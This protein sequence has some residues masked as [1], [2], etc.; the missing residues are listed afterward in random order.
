MMPI[1][2]FLLTSW[3][4]THILVKGKI[5][6]NQRNWLIIKSQFLEGVLTCHQCCGFWV[7][8]I[9]YPFF[10]DLPDCF[11]LYVDF[12]FWGFI[13]SGFNSVMNGV[14]YFLFSNNK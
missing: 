8:M 9:L 3:G 1:L 12:V 7:G 6:E 5:F 4:L 14:I 11:Y 13:S 10:K 2:L